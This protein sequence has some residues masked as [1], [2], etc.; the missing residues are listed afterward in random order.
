MHIQGPNIVE[1]IFLNPSVAVLIRTKD[2]PLL[3]ERALSSVLKQTYT[4]W[5]IIVVNNGG[6][7]QKV[8]SVID[9]FKINSNI[10]INLINLP[11][12]Y[13]MEVATNA[14][15]KETNSKFVAILDDDDTWDPLFLEKCVK[16]LQEDNSIDGVA[17]QSMIVFEEIAENQI[18]EK[19][20]Q[21]FNPN[22][23][24][25]SKL[26]IL[27]KNLFTTNSFVYRRKVIDEIGLYREDLPVLGDWEFNMRFS[28]S[29]K[30]AVI[31]EPLCFYHKRINTHSENYKNSNINEHIKYD[32]ILRKEYFSKFF[33]YRR[34]I[35][36]FAI[37]IFG[38]LNYFLRLLKKVFSAS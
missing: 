11:E 27:R 22:F 36:A 15:L 30:I 10:Q 33:K 34:P 23:K 19:Y 1:V 37:V 18:I 20:K 7:I 2:R 14:G 24:H 6:N 16:T 21:L 29:K 25:V 12:P 28:L 5:E 35:N 31:S 32:W 3:L 8:K 9:L 4:N 17:T 38:S 26:L 13:Y